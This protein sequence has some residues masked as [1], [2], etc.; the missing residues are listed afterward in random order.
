MSPSCMRFLTQ[1]VGEPGWAFPAAGNAEAAPR[2]PAPATAVS[3]PAA[4]AE[5][6]LG[7]VEALAL[8]AYGLLQGSD[9]ATSVGP[10]KFGW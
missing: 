4:S 8:L 1:P 2:L 10:E 7:A 6:G 9:G 5:E 3:S